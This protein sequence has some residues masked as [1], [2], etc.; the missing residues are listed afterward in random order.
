MTTFHRGH[1]L[2]ATLRSLALAACALGGAETAQAASLDGAGHFGVEGVPAGALDP[3]SGGADGLFD[4]GSIF[5]YAFDATSYDFVRACTADSGGRAVLVGVVSGGSNPWIG[6]I[7][8]L[9]T[10]FIDPSFGSSG[11]GGVQFG[12]QYSNNNPTSVAR[13]PAGGGY[14]VA[15]SLDE[16]LVGTRAMFFRVTATGGIDPVF[17]LK[18][19]P[20]MRYAQAVA[21]DPMNGAIW[22]AGTV[23]DESDGLWRVAKHA[24]DGSFLAATTFDVPGS[25]RGGPAAIALQ[26][27]GKAVVVGW[28]NFTDANTPCPAIA[29]LLPSAALDGSFGPPGNGR[30]L[31]YFGPPAFGQSVAVRPNGRIL[32][33]GEIGLF[34]G[35]DVFVTQFLA[36]GALD[37]LG[38]GNEGTSIVGFDLGG[39]NSDG[40]LG[41]NSMA[42]G[43]DGK[44]LV[45]ARALTGVPTNVARV[46]VARLTSVGNLDATFGPTGDGRSV[47][48]FPL[49]APGNGDDSVAC[50]TTVAGKPLVTGAT[51][52]N[53][54]DYDFAAL[55]LTNAHI[56][57]DGF[58]S[59]AIGGWGTP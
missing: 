51:Q 44:V 32:V 38:F 43:T 41:S 37:E 46:G 31:M 3:R 48:D 33:S 11:L 26:P 53:N 52:W 25:D 8:V 59:G 28:A 22:V 4:N 9:P 7:R 16:A 20:G 12:G 23:S 47:H 55:R 21:I 39:S 15:G 58:E 13:E 10:G 30:F 42:L 45:A 35:E 27:D 18:F 29:R 34:G 24:A 17:D 19:P 1:G 57:S 56:F 49:S 6:Y 5:N 40:S 36:G 54:S 2:G 14:I 50:V